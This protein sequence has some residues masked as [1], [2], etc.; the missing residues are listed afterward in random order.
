[1]CIIPIIHTWISRQR[2][3]SLLYMLWFKRSLRDSAEWK[4][5]VGLF[6]QY[7]MEGAMSH[8]ESLQVS[9]AANQMKTCCKEKSDEIAVAVVLH[10]P[11]QSTS[12]WRLWYGLPQ[13]HQIRNILKFVK[14][15]PSAIQK[16]HFKDL[17]CEVFPVDLAR[18]GWVKSA[19]ALR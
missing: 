5:F 16:F 4:P 9:P 7:S 10:F 19:Q 6:Q 3:R 15:S 2:R 14:V 17:C 8:C 18:V 11:H 1:M 12:P 13:G